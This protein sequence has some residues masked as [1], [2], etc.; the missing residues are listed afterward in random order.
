[1]SLKSKL[2]WGIVK[3]SIQLLFYAWCA[4]WG[5]IGILLTLRYLYIEFWLR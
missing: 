2:I 1:M 5:V 3:S 4:M